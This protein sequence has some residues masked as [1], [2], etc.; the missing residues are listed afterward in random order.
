MITSLHIRI[1][2]NEPAQ[3]DYSQPLHFPDLGNLKALSTLSMYLVYAERDEWI[4][5]ME[6]ISNIP[7]PTK[8]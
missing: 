8:E 7:G 4:D 2:V 3:R 5:H 6:D 1:E